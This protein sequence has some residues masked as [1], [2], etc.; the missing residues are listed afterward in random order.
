MFLRLSQEEIHIIKSNI[1]KTI[2]DAE[3]ILFG[4]RVY[5]DKK[6]GDIDIFVKTCKSVNLHEQIKILA[7]IEIAGISRKV[8]LIVKTPESEDQSLFDTI[9]KEGIVL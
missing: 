3:I 8:D 5:D 1:L 2:P 7:D 9:Y 6:G 4:S